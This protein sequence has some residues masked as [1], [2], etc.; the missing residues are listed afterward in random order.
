MLNPSLGAFFKGDQ[1]AL[2]KENPGVHVWGPN[3]VRKGGYALR[4]DL[5]IHRTSKQKTLVPENTFGSCV[6]DR[7]A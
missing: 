1:V 7:G 2:G 6:K 4:L 5:G 3:S